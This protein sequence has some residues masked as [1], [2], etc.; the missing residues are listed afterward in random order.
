[1]EKIISKLKFYLDSFLNLFKKV[2]KYVYFIL[3]ISILLML[4][5]LT[6]RVAMGHDHYFHFSN[7]LAIIS[8]INLFKLHIFAPKIFGGIANGFG[9]GTGIFY[10]PLAY[11][12]AGHLGCFIEQFGF[13][14]LYAVTI[15][16]TI[17]LFLS[18]YFMYKLSLKLFKDEKIALLSGISYICTPYFISDIYIRCSFAE[19]FT[20]LFVPVVF[21]GLYYLYNKNYKNFLIYFVIGFVGMIYSHLVL[22]VYLTLFVLIVLIINYKQF[23]NAKTI[24]YLIISGILILLITCPFYV[25]IFEHKLFGNYMVFENGVMANLGG[26]ER[27]SLS[28]ADLFLVQPLKVANGI[29]VFLNLVVCFLFILLI[30]NYKKVVKDNEK[31]IFK[32]ALIFIIASLIIMVCENIWHFVPQ[33]FW[34][35]QFPWRIELFLNFALCIIAGLSIRL[36]SGE[37][38]KA[39][40]LLTSFGIVIFALVSISTDKIATP[41]RPYDNPDAALGWSYEYLPVKTYDNIDYYHNRDNDIHIMSGIASTDI[42]TDYAPYLLADID[43]KSDEAVLELPRL[44]YLGYKITLDDNESAKE[45]KYFEDKKGF[46][47]VKVKTS[48]TLTVKYTGGLVLLVTRI[49]SFTTVIICFILLIISKKKEKRKV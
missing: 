32:N 3:L 9:Y 43:L 31:I 47:E 10:P 45:L 30:F 44:Y 20:F 23:L 8:D 19:L 1:M 28:L 24:K 34:L 16:E 38:K 27:H 7:L 12:F 29:N 48:G 13:N 36:F 35:I 46:I 22:S 18:G 14:S 17:V 5:I 25:L 37:V 4:P 26:L 40:I 21:L 11:F 42:K 49:I 39:F 2:P 6:G 15:C 33:T 41:Y